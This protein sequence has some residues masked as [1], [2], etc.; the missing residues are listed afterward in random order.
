MCVCWCG[1]D[2][3]PYGAT[4]GP[5]WP[6]HLAGERGRGETA[7]ERDAACF[8]FVFVIVWGLEWLK[9]VMK[10]DRFR[11]ISGRID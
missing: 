11:G 3:G 9:A 4:T 1:A 6:I 5:S 2:L 7:S 8:V 10:R